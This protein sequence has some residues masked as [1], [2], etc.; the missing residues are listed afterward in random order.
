MKHSLSL[1]LGLVGGALLSLSL[2]SCGSSGGGGTTSSQATPTET[3]ISGTVQ[4]PGGQVAFFKKRS[5]EDLFVTEAYAALNGLSSVPDNTIVELAR[6]NANATGSTVITT[7]TTSG[8]RY[9]F[10]LTSLGLHPA[11][12]L[13]VRV[14]G[15]NGREM[16]AFVIGTVADISPVSEAGCQLIMQTLGNG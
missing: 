9:S 8:G 15:S 3:I 16:R 14:T 10:N 12:D 13:I 2:S 7:T 6:L 5:F 1:V 11:H 4:A